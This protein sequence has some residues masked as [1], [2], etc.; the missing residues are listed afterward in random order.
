M[1]FGWIWVVQVTPSQN[2]SW[3]GVPSGSAYQPGCAMDSHLFGLRLN[4]ASLDG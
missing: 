2:R 4:A 3:F 1:G